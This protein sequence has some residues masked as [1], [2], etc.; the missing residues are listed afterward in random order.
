MLRRVI[1]RH[2]EF[3]TTKWTRRYVTLYMNLLFTTSEVNYSSN[4]LFHTNRTF[5]HIIGETNN[6]V[7]D[8]ELYLYT[9]NFSK[10]L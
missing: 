7:L 1:R 4:K 9:L 3:F 6:Y 2:Q 8:N 10:T 5:I